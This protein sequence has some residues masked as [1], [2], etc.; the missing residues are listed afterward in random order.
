MIHQ[1]MEYIYTIYEFGSI[2]QAADHLCITQPA[3]SIALRKAEEELG[4]QIFDRGTR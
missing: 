3:L 2:R 1:Q 4:E